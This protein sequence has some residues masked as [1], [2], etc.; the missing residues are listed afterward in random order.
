LTDDLD[1]TVLNLLSYGLY[2]VA[3]KAQD[4]MN[5]LIVN[6]VIQVTAKPPR[7]AVSINKTNHTHDLISNSR[8]FSVSILDESTPMQFI[9]HFGFKSGRDVGKLADVTFIKGTDDCPII[10]EHALGFL[11]VLVTQ[12]I[13]V[14]THTLFV[15]DVV[16]GQRLRE[17]T[18]L[19]YA[20]YH[21]VKG[22]KTPQKAATYIEPAAESSTT[23]LGAEQ[24]PYRCEV[25]GWVY[26]PALGDPDGGVPPGTPFEDLPDDWVCPLC[27]A[28]KDQFTPT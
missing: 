18:P 20:Y 9:G 16:R 11:E 22:G 1:P 4:M 17:G 2:V 26:N 24:Q 25:C 19:T 3:S 15:G 8:M 6:T 5:G 13:D 14:G 27:G 28:R 10:T 12:Q 7:V 21:Q 23:G